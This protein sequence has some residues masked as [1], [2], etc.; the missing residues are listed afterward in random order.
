MA[1]EAAYPV[2]DER[3]AELSWFVVFALTNA[4]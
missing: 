2:V 4:R 1:V 3:T